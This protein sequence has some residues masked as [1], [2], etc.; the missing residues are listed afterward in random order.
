M[1]DHLKYERVYMFCTLSVVV[2]LL[3]YF[4]SKL[5]ATG[6]ISL[7]QQLL[8]TK[9]FIIETSFINGY[10]FIHEV[11]LPIKTFNFQVDSF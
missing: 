2:E 10:H 3:K 4:F 1:K 11:N 8:Q 6:S 5:E 7:Q 9:S